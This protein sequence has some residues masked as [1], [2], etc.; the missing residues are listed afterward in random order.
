MG[1][2]V[3]VRPFTRGRRGSSAAGRPADP[4]EQAGR[5]RS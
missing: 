1:T 4:V 5:T 3:T 2:A